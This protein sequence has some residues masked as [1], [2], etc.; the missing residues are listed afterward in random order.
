VSISV[1]L[2]RRT[3]KSAKNAKIT[4]GTT[5]DLGGLAVSHFAVKPAQ[6]EFRTVTD[7]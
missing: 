7:Q 4:K 1:L 3:A 6:H 2:D 5:E